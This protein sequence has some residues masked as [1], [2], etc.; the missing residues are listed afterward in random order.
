M[1]NKPRRVMMNLTTWDKLSTKG[2]ETLDQL[3]QEDKEV[4]L[5]YAQNRGT[6]G[7]G[8]Q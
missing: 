4:I 2:K 3:T 8:G 6:N 5:T 1:Q 7:T